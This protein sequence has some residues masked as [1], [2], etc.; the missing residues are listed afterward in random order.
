M[1]ISCAQSSLIPLCIF[2]F[3]L[4]RAG[5]SNFILSTRHVLSS[6]VFYLHMS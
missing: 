1:F 6:S 4:P 5:R 3:I 2:F